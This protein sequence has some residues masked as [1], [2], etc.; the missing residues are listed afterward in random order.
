MSNAVDL[1]INIVSKA[2]LSAFDDVTASANSAGDAVDALG[3]DSAESARKI[4]LSADAADDL[5]G[6][7]GKTT[8]ALGALSSGFELVG[9]GG[10]ATGL[11]SA[12]MATDFMSGAG[13]A[14]NLVMEST[15]VKTV[16]AKVATIGSSI[17]SGAAAA[18]TGVQTAAQWALNAAMSAN[19][20]G[21]VVI[22]AIALVAGLVLL[23]KKSGAFR[24]II[25]DVG[26]VGKKAVSAVVDTVSSLVGLVKDKLPGA[27]D[28]AK[29]VIVTAVKIYTL[30]IRTAID[31][32]KNLI[33]FVK[34][35]LPGAFTKAVDK[36]KS[37]G[38]ALLKPFKDVYDLIKK[39]IDKID[40]IH[41]PK[42]PDLNPF[43][44]V[45]V[46]STG[47][48]VTG[49]GVVAVGGDTFVFNIPAGLIGTPDT[50]ARAMAQ[51]VP[52]RSRR[53]GIL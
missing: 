46:G 43:S 14:L 50:L 6:K 52:R 39:I 13:D 53:F 3:N 44:K 21:L 4:G 38:A 8:G 48:S 26:K 47:T 7:A 19:P 40:D 35:D 2:S 33:G 10:F 28:K 9:L 36:A 49:S 32:V 27:F 1:A 5:A 41:L 20:I 37:I 11:Q 24:D 17:A 18:A 45:A 25:S 31:V 30:P 42:L 16:A 15:A 29:S 12:A 34:N 22:A 51:V 23:Y